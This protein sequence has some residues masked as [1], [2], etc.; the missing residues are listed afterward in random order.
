MNNSNQSVNLQ[1][2]KKEKK[3]PV[4][5]QYYELKSKNLDKILMFQLGDFYEI[6]GEDA[7]I[8]AKILK[9]QLTSR[10]KN[11]PDALPMCGFPIHAAEHYIHKIVTAGYKVAICRQTGSD[12]TTGLMKREVVRIVTPST[13]LNENYLQAEKN[14]FLASIAFQQK[15]IGLSYCDFSTGEFFIEHCN[16]I[17]E[18]INS[19]NAKQPAEILLAEQINNQPDILIEPLKNKLSYY[20]WFVAQ[21][22]L[23]FLPVK[24]FQFQ[25]CQEEILA[26]L[27]LRFLSSLGLTDYPTVVCSLGAIIFYLKQI[28]VDKEI[29]IQNVSWIEKDD[30]VLLD[31]A[32]MEHLNLFNSIDDAPYIQSLFQLL[33]Q[34]STP[35]GARLLRRWI[36]EPLINVEKISKR[37]KAIKELIQ[38]KQ[39]QEELSILLKNITDIE[40]LTARISLGHFWLS[41]F[42]KIK[43]SLKILPTLSE[44]LAKFTNPLFKIILQEWDSLKE[45]AD[46]LEKAFAQELPSNKKTGG[47]IA[48]GYSAKLDEWKE[49]AL[50]GKQTIQSIE[51]QEKERSGIQNLKIRYNQNVGFFIEVSKNQLNLV[52]STYFKKQTLTNSERFTT[53]EL[54]ELEEKI[55][56]ADEEVAILE[57]QLLSKIVKQFC[58]DQKK[59]LKTA[60]IISSIDCLQA[61]AQVAW[62]RNY[63]QPEFF[64]TEEQ[65]IE[66]NE[67]RHPI[68]E[69]NTEEEPFIANDLVLDQN[70]QFIQIITGPNMGGKSTYMRQAA[71][72][73]IMA[74]IGSFV[75]ASKAKLSIF[76][77]IF[78]RVGAA[79]NILKGESTFM[80]EMNEAATIVKHSTIKS[81]VILDEI[82]RGTSTND[83]ISIAWSILEFLH[84][85][86]VLTL[87]ATH[88]HELVKLENNLSGVL[89]TYILTAKKDDEIILLKKIKQGFSNQSYGIQVAKIAGLPD[90]II[91]RAQ[92]VLAKL[93]AT[94]KGKEQ[95]LDN[96]ENI[97]TLPI[98]EIKNPLNERMAKIDLNNTTPLDALN[99]LQELKKLAEQ[100]EER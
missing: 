80:V 27:N 2:L 44:I 37:Q 41:D 36:S 55:L 43:S 4:E 72:I 47:Y 19:L 95:N 84:K 26:K 93:E 28:Q 98:M 5:Q 21:K 50:Q 60:K 56:S 86:R 38:E 90:V 12:A 87:F 68:I 79:D 65:K 33:N 29:A 71:L 75:P 69:A 91:K 52:P 11:Q 17:T 92:Q 35:M 7:S 31:N 49:I 14:N 45:L 51:K 23:Q 76:K 32:T 8:V 88:Y 30:R 99:L 59:L 3:S 1:S 22:Q 39:L 62:Q 89:N 9:I 66:I 20:S 97:S 48:E 94:R 34:C 61:L 40:R 15:E 54:R 64:E 24:F 25:N 74:Q 13:I 82:G 81:F 6:F 67:A 42:T 10:N 85:N 73:I 53:K 18:L 46:F 83:G 100:N 70:K 16:S 63:I 77:Q 57:E 96:K 58:L 78:T